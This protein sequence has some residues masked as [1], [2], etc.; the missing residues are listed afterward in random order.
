MCKSMLRGELFLCDRL[1]FWW[2]L[3][4]FC[5]CWG[6]FLPLMCGRKLI[7]NESLFPPVC[8][9]RDAVHGRCSIVFSLVDDHPLHVCWNW[10][11]ETSDC[12][13][14]QAAE[15]AVECSENS[16]LLVLRSRLCPRCR[17]QNTN[18]REPS[19]LT[20][21]ITFCVPVSGAAADKPS[22]VRRGRAAAQRVGVSGRRGR[23]ARRVR[24]AAAAA[25]GQVRRVRG[26]QDKNLMQVR[27]LLSLK[28]VSSWWHSCCVLVHVAVQNIS[29]RYTSLCPI[30][31]V[32]KP[33][34]FTMTF[35]RTVAIGERFFT[36]NAKMRVIQA[37]W[38]PGSPIDTHIVVLTSDNYLRCC[39]A[40]QTNVACCY[41]QGE[42]TW[43]LQTAKCISMFLVPL[44][45]DLWRVQTWRGRA[46][47]QHKHRRRLWKLQWVPLQHQPGTGRGVWKIKLA[48]DITFGTSV[49][50]CLCV[51]K[52][53][54]KMNRSMTH[55]SWR[56]GST[57]AQPWSC[58]GV[59]PARC[60]SSRGIRKRRAPSQRSRGPSS[61]CGATGTC[62]HCWPPCH[63]SRE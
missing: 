29:F 7:S 56:W 39:S 19:V 51:L 45:Q 52:I 27:C 41:L 6:F 62:T 63:R 23:D 3:E 38:H 30:W 59:A 55:Y 25:L 8:V 49:C 40:E 61:C 33:F 5:C 47:V 48:V 57:S 14:R 20:C 35:C 10:T 9:F 36:S 1:F 32:S 18:L 24:A 37:A 17:K 28:S 60:S 31:R 11:G 4:Y 42:T 58:R 16:C 44:C 13:T 26:R 54:T 21:E 22:G 43:A 50:L 15:W 2:G 46:D 53:V 34:W 12:G